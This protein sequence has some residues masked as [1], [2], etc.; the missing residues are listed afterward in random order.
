MADLTFYAGNENISTISEDSTE[1]KL[2]VVE[3]V[4]AATSLNEF[5]EENGADTTFKVV[6]AFTMPGVR[7]GRGQG[8]TDTP[9]MNTYLITSDGQCLMTQSE[10]IYRSIAVILTAFPG[11]V[12]DGEKGMCVRVATKKLRS[13]NTIK[14]LVPVR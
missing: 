3:A 9:C 14:S 11:F 2:A 5:I 12:V 13:G 4:N 1:N 8:Q 7:K 10:G 6:D